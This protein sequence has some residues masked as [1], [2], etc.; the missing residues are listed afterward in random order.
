MLLPDFRFAR[1]PQH[2]QLQPYRKCPNFIMDGNFNFYPSSSSNPERLQTHLFLESEF[3]TYS[4]I[5]TDNLSSSEIL[6]GLD[7]LGSAPLDLD[8]GPQSSQDLNFSWDWSLLDEH[9]QWG[10]YDGD[11]LNSG[12]PSSFDFPIYPSPI[13]RGEVLSEPRPKHTCIS[14]RPQRRE[15]TSK[16]SLPG[17][18]VLNLGVKRKRASV[19]CSSSQQCK[20]LVA[21][22]DLGKAYPK[23]R[24]APNGSICIK[25]KLHK[26]QAR[27]NIFSQP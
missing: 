26:G 17:T 23:P 27:S 2:S 14:P 16:P 15:K 25:C 19:E 4:T 8:S 18:I 13:A 11:I 20:K 22:G 21:E 7:S 9:F 1:V 3:G 24:R 6:L 10:D 5:S 12:L